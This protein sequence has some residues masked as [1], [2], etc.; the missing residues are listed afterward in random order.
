MGF[1]RAL[2]LLSWAALSLAASQ[3]PLLFA[4]SQSTCL[5]FNPYL[6]SK[7]VTR[8]QALNRVTSQH[9]DI[10]LRKQLH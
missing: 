1:L 7:N 3:E 2:S 4:N 10:D 6:Y 9:V 5:D 8:C